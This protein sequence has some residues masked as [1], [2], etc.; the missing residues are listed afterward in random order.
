MQKYIFIVLI[1]VFF[2]TCTSDKD[3]AQRVISD[4]VK[5]YATGNEKLLKKVLSKKLREKYDV[6]KNFFNSKTFK[7]VKK[8]LKSYSIIISRV[9]QTEKGLRVK[10]YLNLNKKDKRPDIIVL[11]KEND[12]WKI[13]E[14]GMFVFK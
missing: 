5:S 13:N 6:Y 11:I 10:Y 9:K 8:E 4:Y 2:I 3:I 14:T 7:T 1:P 12:E